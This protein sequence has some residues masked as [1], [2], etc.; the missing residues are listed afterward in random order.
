MKTINKLATIIVLMC[1]L[2]SCDPREELTPPYE[3]FVEVENATSKDLT[4]LVVRHEPKYPSN[5]EPYTVVSSQNV[6]Q[7]GD[8]QIPTFRIGISYIHEIDVSV[9]WNCLNKKRSRFLFFEKS[10]VDEMAK[11]PILRE[12]NN[13]EVLR[14]YDQSV[15]DEHIEDK[16]IFEMNYDVFTPELWTQRIQKEPVMGAYW[17]YYSRYYSNIDTNWYWYVYWT[18]TLTDEHLA[19]YAAGKNLII[20]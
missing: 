11:L 14:I 15:W 9:L 2:A 18:F 7:I 6:I 17:D 13:G 5:I 19:E 8:I 10:V 3:C 1:S 4:L 12:G 16:I 20:N